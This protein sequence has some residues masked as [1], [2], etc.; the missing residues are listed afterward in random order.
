MPSSAGKK[1]LGGQARRQ[2]LRRAADLIGQLVVQGALPDPLDE[3][4]ADRL[5]PVDEVAG[6]EQIEGRA[7]PLPL[8]IGADVGAHRL[9]VQA[10]HLVPV[11]FNGAATPEIYTLSLHDALPI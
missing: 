3:G 6:E 4:A 8:R 11:F 5:R 9:L 7:A 2:L 10:V 1:K